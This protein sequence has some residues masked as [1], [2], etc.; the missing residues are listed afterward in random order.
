MYILSIFILL[1]SIRAIAYPETVSTRKE[2]IKDRFEKKT[3][4]ND[5]ILGNTSPFLESASMSSV[6]SGGACFEWYVTLTEGCHARD[7]E[8]SSRRDTFLLLQTAAWKATLTE[9][10]ADFADDHLVESRSVQPLL[11][12]SRALKPHLG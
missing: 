6:L 1:K 8:T 7:T 9:R 4:M 3:S 2:N 11:A 5:E 12:L 10:G